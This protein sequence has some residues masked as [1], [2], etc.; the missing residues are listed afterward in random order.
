MKQH[1]STVEGLEAMPLTSKKSAITQPNGSTLL[2]IP[3]QNRA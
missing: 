3:P 1:E 2:E